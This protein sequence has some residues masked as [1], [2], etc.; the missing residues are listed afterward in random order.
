MLPAIPLAKTNGTPLPI[1]LKASESVMSGGNT[2]FAGRLCIAN[3]SATDILRGRK[4]CTW[5]S[6]LPYAAVGE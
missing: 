5:T 1:V 6:L 2:K 3:A 4:G